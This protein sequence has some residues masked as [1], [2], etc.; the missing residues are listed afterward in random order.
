MNCRGKVTFH[1]MNLA[2]KIRSVWLDLLWGF[3]GPFYSFV[4]L[5]R[6]YLSLPEPYSPMDLGVR[7]S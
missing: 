1:V 6:S 4:F 5:S 2:K 3:F 7:F